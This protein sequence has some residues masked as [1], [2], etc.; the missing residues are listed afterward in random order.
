[1]STEIKDE[2]A[3]PWE[4]LQGLPDLIVFLACLCHL[5]DCFSEIFAQVTQNRL[6]SHSGGILHWVNTELA[7]K[8]MSFVEDCQGSDSTSSSESQ[9]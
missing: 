9:L 3:F 6:L 8:N 7:D 2:S 4:I 1:M 5:S